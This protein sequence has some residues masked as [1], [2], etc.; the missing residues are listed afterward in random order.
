[1]LQH[2]RDKE[3]EEFADKEKF[4]TG[5]YKKQMEEVR[6]A[7]E[8]ERLKEGE[9]EGDISNLRRR[10]G[11]GDGVQFV[12][13]PEEKQQRCRVQGRRHFDGFD[14]RFLRRSADHMPLSGLLTP[15]VR[16]ARLSTTL[17]YLKT[18]DTLLS[19]HTY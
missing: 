6:K 16:Y 9:F 15:E 4:V 13:V 7:E 17:A 8:E 12:A 1:M 3:G 10:G 14:R 11:V 5:A 18:K 19:L 2:E